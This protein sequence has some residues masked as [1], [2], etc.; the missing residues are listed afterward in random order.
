MEE[1][2]PAIDDTRDA[3]VILSMRTLPDVPS[4]TVIGALTRVARTLE[5]NHSRLMIA[6]VTPAIDRMLHRSGVADLLGPDAIVPATDEVFES[7]DTALDR[8]RRWIG[9]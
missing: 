5:A 9:S 3:V 1:S 4:A 8:A 7:L 6:G 2:W